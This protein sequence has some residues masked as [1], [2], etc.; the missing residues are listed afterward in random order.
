[1]SSPRYCLFLDTE[2]SDKPERLGDDLSDMPF[3]VQA[4]WVIY[5]RDAN[6]IKEENLLIRA[7]DYHISKESE[8]VHG[9]SETEVNSRGVSRKDMLRRMARDIRRYKPLVV[10]HYVDLD[11]QMIKNS[12]RRAG[13]KNFLKGLPAFCTMKA[14]ADYIQIP[15][16]N[17]PQLQEIY[18]M[19]FGK[20]FVGAHNA[21]RDAYATAEVFFELQRRGEVNEDVIKS[22]Q[23]KESPAKQNSTGCGLVLVLFVFSLL[24][25]L[26]L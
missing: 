3:I 8:R 2:T 10:G 11:I 13:M 22:Q 12:T 6:F 18:R 9:I 17:Y 21:L 24:V 14:T 4:S 20:K 19:L 26:L 25:H 7:D 16:R 1:M 15:H 23:E 5:D